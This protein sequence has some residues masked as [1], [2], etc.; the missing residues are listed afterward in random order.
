MPGVTRHRSTSGLPAQD[1]R[2]RARVLRRDRE[3]DRV[4]EGRPE[5]EH[6]RDDVEEQADAVAGVEIVANGIGG[7]IAQRRA[8]EQRRPVALEAAFR[9]ASPAAAK[10]AATSS[11]SLAS[12]PSRRAAPAPRRPAARRRAQERRGQVGDHARRERRQPL[13]HVDALDRQLD[14][15]RLCIGRRGLERRRLVVAA[16]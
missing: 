15:V 5:A 11:T 4:G 13:A 7:H 8:S 14:A 2:H 3:E 12:I 9:L 10:A 6:D 1:R 16:A